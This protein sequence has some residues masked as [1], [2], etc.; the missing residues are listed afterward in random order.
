MLIVVFLFPFLRSKTQYPIR[1]RSHSISHFYWANQIQA[2]LIC[3]ILQDL[4]GQHLACNCIFAKFNLN[5]LSLQDENLEILNRIFFEVN[6]LNKL[7]FVHFS[8]QWRFG[9]YR[10]R[11]GDVS[12]DE[13]LDPV[14]L[15]RVPFCSLA[16]PLK[17]FSSFSTIFALFLGNSFTFDGAFLSSFETLRR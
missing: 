5:R 16:P 3:L 7:K 15:L 17:K 14:L 11:F 6:K 12:A 13:S 9:N 2:F 1:F 8:H 4:H 10:R